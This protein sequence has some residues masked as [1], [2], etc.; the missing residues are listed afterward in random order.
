MRNSDNGRNIVGKNYVTGSETVSYP[1]EKLGSGKA[2]VWGEG[3]SGRK[4]QLGVGEEGAAVRRYHVP[5]GPGADGVAGEEGDY[6]ER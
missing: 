1:F 5:V 4:T 6:L 2:F 3:V